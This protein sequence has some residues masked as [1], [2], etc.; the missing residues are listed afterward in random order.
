MG[1]RC[2]IIVNFTTSINPHLYSINLY[3]HLW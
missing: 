3:L 2:F 1:G